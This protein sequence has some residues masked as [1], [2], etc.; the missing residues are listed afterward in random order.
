M[1]MTKELGAGD[2]GR[3][4]EVIEETS[5]TTTT[6][7]SSSVTQ[8]Q[9]SETANAFLQLLNTSGGM[10]CTYEQAK[11]KAKEIREGKRD[12]FVKNHL[13]KQA[14]QA[15]TSQQILEAPLL[16]RSNS[17][18]RFPNRW[19]NLRNPSSSSCRL[20]ANKRLNSSR[21]NISN[22]TFNSN[23]SHQVSSINSRTHF[24]SHPPNS[25]FNLRLQCSS[26]S[27]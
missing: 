3:V 25:K 27:S 18:S 12:E 10:G 13:E 26:S 14:L 6:T 11:Q 22:L 19:S 7:T 8:E 4:Q 16:Q 1:K 15:T 17:S 21:T 9:R 2:D 23:C 5:T 20:S 24:S